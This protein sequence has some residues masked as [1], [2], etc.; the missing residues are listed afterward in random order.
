MGDWA[1]AIGNPLGILRGS[2]TVGIISAQGRGNLNIFG[3]RDL[4]YQDFIQTDASINF[5]NSGGPLCN[6]RGEVPDLI[7][8]WVD[9]AEP[10]RWSDAAHAARLSKVGAIGVRLSR[11][12]TT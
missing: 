6:I 2:V 7:G 10:G 5:G 12:V 9:A 8:L 1:I 3:S 4:S 11:W